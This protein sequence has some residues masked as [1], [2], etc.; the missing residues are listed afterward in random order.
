MIYIAIED[1]KFVRDFMKKLKSRHYASEVLSLNSA[2]SFVELMNKSF[3]SDDILIL[4]ISCSVV[5]RKM[6]QNF[7]RDI[8]KEVSTIIVKDSE[9]ED[10]E[11]SF[12]NL[13]SDLDVKTLI[14]TIVSLQET[15]KLEFSLPAKPKKYF[16][17]MMNRKSV[18]NI[19]GR[20]G[21]LSVVT[22]HIESFQKIG[23][24]YGQGTLQKVKVFLHICFFLCGGGL[25]AFVLQIG[26]V[27]IQVQIWFIIF[28]RS[29]EVWCA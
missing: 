1:K 18:A 17:P 11:V 28:F 29:S 24:E 22:I 10:P 7:L 23:I 9:K 8:S 4:P 6:W 25:E 19:L 16:I 15:N 12:W 20:H 5:S 26:Y 3:N 21:A 13:I 27:E 14:N 2:D